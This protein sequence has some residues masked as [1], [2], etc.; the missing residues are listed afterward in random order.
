MA[1]EIGGSCRSVGIVST[2]QAV[3]LAVLQTEGLR[4]AV[5]YA[6]RDGQTFV[7]FYPATPDELYK[8]ST[9]L[10]RN[11]E[12]KQHLETNQKYVCFTRM[13]LVVCYDCQMS[14]RNKMAANIRHL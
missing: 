3:L 8:A 2:A 5:P 7:V 14:R 4:V 1:D 9:G 6:A 11:S 13:W 10:Y 12:L